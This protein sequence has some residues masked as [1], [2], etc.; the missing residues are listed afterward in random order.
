MT[1]S[2]H[3]PDETDVLFYVLR[4]KRLQALAVLFFEQL[5]PALWPPLGIAAAFLVYALLELPAYLPPW[6]QV[7]VE[8]AFGVAVIGSLARGLRR[9]AWPDRAAAD[10]RLERASDLPHRPLEILQDRPALP[11][12]EALWR[13]H[14]A[15]ARASI[16]RLRAGLPR[17]G[18]AARDRRALRALALLSLVAALVVAGEQA[19]GRVAKALFPHFAPP[20]VPAEAVLQAWITPPAHTGLAPIFLKAEGGAVTVPDGAH[21]TVNLSGG[22]HAVPELIQPG[23]PLAFQTIGEAS[24]QADEDLHSGGRIEVRRGGRRVAGWDITLVE[25][26]APEVRFPETP[27]AVA[28]GRIPQ[29]RIPW[30]V[31]HAYGVTSLQAELRLADRPDA[32]PLVIAIPLPG[33]APKHA[34]G[35]LQQDLTPNPWAGLPVIAQLRGH[36]ATGLVGTSA[37]ARLIL[38][39]R[40]FDN[41]L[42]RALME[43]RK[44]LTL[45]PSE[46]RAAILALE[47]LASQEDAWRDDFGA[48]LNLWSIIAQ[49]AHD[50]AGGAVPEVQGRMWQLALHL[51][52]GAVERTARALDQAKQALRDLLDA[53]KRG[54]QADRGELDRRTRE[55]EE[56]LRRHLEA[57]AEQA[58]RDPSSQ[59]FDPDSQMLDSRQLQQLAEQMRE[60]ARKGD[61]EAARQKLAELEKLLQALEQGRQQ[62]RMTDRQ[63]LQQQRRQR[64]E[65]QMSA[66]QDMVRRQG[67]LLDHAEE[68]NPP[69]EAPNPFRRPGFGTPPAPPSDPARGAAQRGEDLKVQQALRRALGELMQQ[70]GD[71]TGQIPPNLGEADSA[72]RDAGQALAEG[73]DGAAGRSAQKAIEAL[74]KGARQMSDTIASMFGQQGDQQGDQP[75]DQMGEDGQDG[76]QPGDGP[77]GNDPYGRNWRYGRGNRPWE[78]GPGMD[79]RDDARRDP[80]GRLLQEGSNGLDESGQTKVPEEMERARTRA[81]QEELRR[82]GADRTRPQP[83]LDYIDRLLR[84]F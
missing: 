78:S 10:R 43:V 62:G 51:E 68:R 15:R 77:N 19:P 65:Q 32:A 18:L 73:R 42:A 50:S 55:V 61:T 48:Y 20:A 22:G 14:I 3:A 76:S 44:R 67:G 74:Q 46:R 56:A 34:R 64:G 54:T 31:S 83:E 45:Q 41:Q 1:D 23:G 53:E 27:G 29:T 80:L 52:E 71:L 72:M 81:I 66:V 36:E 33:G 21:L 13:A 63:R 84:E 70:Y 38:P 2:P 6:V 47:Q 17:P 9:L 39:E 75:G 30:E 5:W 35:A 12:A 49:L 59:A 11:G 58:K 24:F 82:R 69:D 25:N 16:V 8:I 37:E 79:R 26:H 7:G 40:H 28:R 60:A 4:R 57:L